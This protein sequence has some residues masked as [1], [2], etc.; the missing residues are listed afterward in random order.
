MW[1]VT[2]LGYY[3][4]F[5]GNAQKDYMYPYI[6]K[7]SGLQPGGDPSVNPGAQPKL[8]YGNL[9]PIKLPDTSTSNWLDP[10]LFEKM[11][12]IISALRKMGSPIRFI[13]F[14]I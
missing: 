9:N 2:T 8:N 10:S 4:A 11:V 7:V 12:P 13:L 6:V 5:H 1:I 14:M 3:G